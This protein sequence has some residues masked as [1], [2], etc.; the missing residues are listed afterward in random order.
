MDLSLVLVL[1]IVAD[2]L[3]F[4]IVPPRRRVARLV[5]IS[6]FFTFHTFLIVALIGSPLRP[7]FRPKD[8]PRE[9]WLQILTCLW[10]VL[11]AR[12]LVAILALPALL[13]KTTIENKILSDIV[14]ACLYLCSALAILGFVFAL[15]LQGIVATSGVIAIVLGLAL[16]NTLGDVFSGLSLS[17]EK[18]YDVGDAILL[19]GG[20]EGKVVQI[21]WRS[22]HLRNSENDVVIIPHSSMAKMRIQNH[23]AVTARYSGNL[24]VL[25]DS[26]NEP[27][28]AQ[29]ILKQAAMACP[30]ILEEP[31]PSVAAIEFRDDRVTYSIYYSTS[32]FAS[33]PEARSQIITQLWKRARPGHHLSDA[34]PIFFFG[35]DELFDRLSV[36]EPLS[37]EEKTRLTAK[38]VRRHF[39][40]GEQLL[41]QGV[42]A[43]SVHFI[44]YG[45]IQ[46]T[47]Q[48]QDGRVL[49]VRRMG[50]GD[51]F[52]EISLLTGMP[53]SGTLTALTSGLLLDLNSEDLK[54]ILES[55]LELMEL[56]SH[57][58]ARQQHLV[59]VFDKAAIH[60]VVI[61]QPDLL[62]RIKSFFHLEQKD[63][64]QKED[65]MRKTQNAA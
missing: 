32:S 53:A 50:P 7:V 14:A 23:S 64:K 45:I 62:S 38:V 52:G 19:E 43:E 40:A 61:E 37:A 48:V 27:E 26:R 56:L 16:Q 60:P 57:T 24:N 34:G 1:A 9:F 20:V 8:L 2:F 13:R 65:R 49:K 29:E 63:Q 51:S 28:L 3:V 31:A 12:E 30:A 44:F 10:W 25:V 47:R 46:V 42:K 39:K 41:V 36:L 4:K 35:E 59:A 22:T 55:R 21:N 58:V 33:A 6:V 17:V 54:P 11:A 5:C 15:P 18:P